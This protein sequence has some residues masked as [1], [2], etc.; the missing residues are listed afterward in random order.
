MIPAIC[1]M[2]RMELSC[3][4]GVHAEKLSVVQLVMVPIKRSILIKHRNFSHI[5]IFLVYFG[6]IISV[7]HAAQLHNICKYSPHY[8]RHRHSIEMN[9]LV[10]LH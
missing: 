7:L 2:V 8:H 4:P 9:A 10:R 6:K 5:L 1:S 3:C